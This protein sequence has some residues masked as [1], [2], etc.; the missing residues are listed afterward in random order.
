[1]VR[2][3]T[4]VL[5]FALCCLPCRA[6]VPDGKVYLEVPLMV[7]APGFHSVV[8]AYHDGERFF[9]DAALL[10]ERLGY[11]VERQGLQ[12][13]AS[14]VDRRFALDFAL[15]EATRADGT[16]VSLDGDAHNSDRRYLLAIEAL[17]RLFHSDIFFDEA[18]LSLQLSTVAEGFD[19]FALG[20][21][22]YMGS[23]VPGP[24]R[25]GRQRHLLGGV[26]ASWYATRQWH[27]GRANYTD[28]NVH[29]ATSMLG[30]SVRGSL[31]NN[32]EATYLF[33]RPGRTRLTRLEVGRMASAGHQHVDAVRVSNLPLSSLHLQRTATL[34]GRAEPHAMVEVV[35]G[36]H[37][38]DRTQVGQS[39]RYRLRVPAYYGTTE[40]I[41]RVHPLGGA[42]PYEER[43]Y[44]LATP[45]LAPPG[46]L[47]YD[48]VIG[49]GGA[50]HARYGILPRLTARI[51]GQHRGDFRT[52]VAA[53]PVP[54]VVLSADVAWPLRLVQASAHLWHR[55]L[56]T[57]AAFTSEK[58][59]AQGHLVVAGQWQRLSVQLTGSASRS[60]GGW[61]A[62][63]LAPS[64]SYH[65]RG[66]MA[67]RFQVQAAR[68]GGLGTTL[69]NAAA[70]KALAARRGG[71]Q[72][73]LFARG[74]RIVRSGGIE[75]LLTMSH[76]SLG[77]MAAYD[78][79]PRRLLAQVTLQVRTSALGIASRANTDGTHTHSAYG[80]INVGPDLRLT[81][82]LRDETAALLRPFEDLSGN[83]RLDPGEPLLPEVD[84]QLFHA[85]L[86]RTSS[87]AL[88][89]LYLEPYAAYQVQIIEQSIRD[90]WLRPTTGYSFSFI[91]DPGRTKVVDIP[92]QR[93]PLVRGLV[94]SFERPASRLRVRALM[95][96]MPVATAEVYRDGG[97]AL[98][99]AQG[100]YVLRLEDA[101]EETLL[102]QQPLVVPA[103]T[104]VMDVELV[105][106]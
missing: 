38:V 106:E 1:M 103:G 29:F 54:F 62:L 78:P 11:T 61:A 82:A 91:A 23:E 51:S 39:G 14:D 28:G 57:E 10:F 100:T 99:L 90:P 94:R 8:R 43:H 12:L 40:S 93:V 83:G 87:G 44:F 52:G 25:F 24:L 50:L 20:P 41:V 80:S 86:Q 16:T 89:A 69:W 53:S 58:G 97:F 48:A 3:A 92:L 96:G 74:T 73:G 67:A 75:A 84:V 59:H 32:P 45:S 46:R 7:Q 56:S 81:R 101:V 102:L 42:Q 79:T 17:E 98:R 55:H 85:T 9:V 72:L 13:V 15:Q 63:R 18:R 37:V 6:Q 64:L 2:V 65:A 35:T 76:L 47:Y 21:R 60:R 104:R 49:A 26:V 36:G 33:D 4:L 31:G 105:K 34:Q 77:V 70:S 30:G 66:G 22:A 27:T 5:A 71:L 95:D 88:R 68:Y 19:T